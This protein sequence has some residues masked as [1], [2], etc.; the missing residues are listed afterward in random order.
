MAR[1]TKEA[2]EEAWGCERPSREEVGV[3]GVVAFFDNDRTVR[4]RSRGRGAEGALL[5]LLLLLVDAIADRAGMEEALIVS[6]RSEGGGWH[7]RERREKRAI[8]GEE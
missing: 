7:A 1:A 8:K 4:S 5:L 2:A 6:A 3:V